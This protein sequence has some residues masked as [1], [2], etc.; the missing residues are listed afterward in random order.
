M[1]TSALLRAGARVCAIEPDP[2][3]A[4]RLRRAC[5]AAVVVEEDALAAP[6]P[7]K[8]FRVVANLPFAHAT[9]ILRALLSDPRVPLRSA[10]VIVQWEAAVKRARLW[11]STEL[12]VLWG[13][14]YELAVVRRIAPAAFAPAPGVAAALLAATRRGTPLVPVGAAPAYE[15]FLRRAYRSGSLPPTARRLA[16]ALGIDARAEP[17]DLDARAWA[18]LWQETSA[19]P[20][21]V[22]RMSRRGRKR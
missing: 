4:G 1:V 5:P 13:A 8:P 18:A 6:W 20:R 17:R 11:P 21:T 2:T 3:L 7:E 22:R 16:P 12:G 14:W 19:A 15:A 9:D 10:H